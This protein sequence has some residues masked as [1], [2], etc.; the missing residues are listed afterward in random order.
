MLVNPE[1]SR[2]GLIVKLREQLRKVRSRGLTVSQH[3]RGVMSRM[4]ELLLAEESSEFHH[5]EDWPLGYILYAATVEFR[6]TDSYLRFFDVM[7]YSLDK[8][9]KVAEDFLL[10][11]HFVKITP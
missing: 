4:I 1:F 3:Y 11:F 10:D 8:D 9:D 2:R 5:P 6:V 7:Q